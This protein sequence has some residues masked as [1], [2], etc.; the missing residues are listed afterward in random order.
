[1]LWYYGIVN[2]K[3]RETLRRIFEEPIRRDIES[4]EVERLVLALGGR[5]EE[6]T[7]S[8]IALEL[9]GVDFRYP[10][11]HPRKELKRYVIRRLRVFFVEA[12]VET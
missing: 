5:V 7:G 10:R 12:G 1:M 2:S 8:R 6:R 3:N 11:P 9:N 4:H